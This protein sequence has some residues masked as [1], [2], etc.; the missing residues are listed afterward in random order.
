MSPLWKQLSIEDISRLGMG[1]LCS[2]PCL[3]LVAHLN[4]VSPVYAAT[5]AV[6]MCVCVSLVSKKALFP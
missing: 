3:V 2:L 1:S 5:V 6:S 4:C